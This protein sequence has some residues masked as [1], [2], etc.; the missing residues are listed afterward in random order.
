MKFTTILLVSAVLFSSV[1]AAPAAPSAEISLGAGTNATNVQ[2]AQPI[3]DAM[4]GA[5]ASASISINNEYDA[6]GQ[7]SAASER[8]SGSFIAFPLAI[9]H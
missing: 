1:L 4:S 7:S 3:N 2:A 5:A 8:I 6:N 9:K